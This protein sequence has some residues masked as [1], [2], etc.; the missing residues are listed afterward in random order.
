VVDT[1]QMVDLGIVYKSIVIKELI[2]KF[3]KTRG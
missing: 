1:T 2:E 3:L